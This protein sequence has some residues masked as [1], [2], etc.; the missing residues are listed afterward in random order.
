MA[1]SVLRNEL[2]LSSVLQKDVSA[3]LIRVD[4]HSPSSG[5]ATGARVFSELGSSQVYLLSSVSEDCSERSL[6]ENGDS[7]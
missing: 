1:D 2:E 7:A 4:A 5:D 6:F 3:R